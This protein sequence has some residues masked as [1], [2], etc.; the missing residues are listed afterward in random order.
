MLNFPFRKST[1]LNFKLFIR[2]N[3]IILNEKFYIRGGWYQYLSL[4]LL[5]F[6][7]PYNFVPCAQTHATGNGGLPF[8]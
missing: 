5:R 4:C 8:I 2:I 3:S 6:M 7:L 1:L